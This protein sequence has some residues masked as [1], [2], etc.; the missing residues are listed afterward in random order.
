MKQTVQQLHLTGKSVREISRLLK[1]SRNTV[2]AIL[3]KKNTDS[4]DIY[5]AKL[6]EHELIDLIK[7]LLISCKGN[8]VRVHEILQEEHHHKIPYSTLTYIVRKYQLRSPPNQRVGEYIFEPGVE[9]QHDTSP[10]WV[11]IDG[12]KTK[13]QCASLIFGFSRKVFIQ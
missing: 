8:L 1:L 12:K 10:H 6:H 13:T 5:P 2:R 11:E 4:S 7:P 3:R 9:M